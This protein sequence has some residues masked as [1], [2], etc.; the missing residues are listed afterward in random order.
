MIFAKYK[1][2]DMPTI[3]KVDG[4]E[5]SKETYEE[6]YNT[7]ERYEHKKP[8]SIESKL[9]NAYIDWDIM[10]KY[11][12]VPLKHCEKP[13]V[14]IC[15]RRPELPDGTSITNVRFN[16]PAT[17]VWFDDGTKVVSKAGHGDKYNPEVGFNVC[18]LKK[19]LGNKEYHKL[20]DWYVFDEEEDN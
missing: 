19:L 1:I 18:L 20:L 6:L 12:G 8:D 15:N 7:E 3:Y 2:G 9:D 10:H 13:Y 16:N 14:K 5:V 17:I 11:F 4:N